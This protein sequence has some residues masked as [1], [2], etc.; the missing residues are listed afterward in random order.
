MKKYRYWP[1]F[2]LLSLIL[3]ALILCWV[4]PDSKN[5]FSGQIMLFS[6]RSV[7]T[8]QGAILSSRFPLG[9]TVWL[10]FLQ[11]TMFFWLPPRQVLA[12]TS[13]F[14]VFT[15]YFSTLVGIWLG[16]SLW[17]GLGRLA[18]S[19]ITKKIQVLQP[20]RIS[21]FGLA[22]GG[23]W[24]LQGMAA[25]VALLL[26]CGKSPYG[27]TIAGLLFGEALIIGIYSQVC[28]PFRSLLPDTW[29]IILSISG[30]LIL[31][32]TGWHIWRSIHKHI[33]RTQYESTN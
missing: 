22:L 24:I 28:S 4:L 8:L 31:L 32:L 11:S 2:C 23:V 14:G 27:Q 7:Q 15:G 19:S 20:F 16:V 6:Q 3:L 17:Y 12:A 26:G 1:R 5:W 10:S 9:N 33:N 13:S 29:K 25:P 18:F 30:G 21:S